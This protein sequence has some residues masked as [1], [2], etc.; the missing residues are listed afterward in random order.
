MTA[1]QSKPMSNLQAELLKLYSNNLND[2]D[3]NEIKL[4][5]GNYFAKKATDAMDEVW[6]KQSL[7]KQDMI[8]WTTEHNRIEG[9][10]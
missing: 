1:L 3:L 8:N 2:K 7:S 9:S 5:L 10:N 6:E 4:I